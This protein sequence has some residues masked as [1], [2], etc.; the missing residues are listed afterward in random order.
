MPGMLEVWSA[1]QALAMLEKGILMSVQQLPQFIALPDIEFSLLFL[2]VGIERGKKC[3]IGSAYFMH[4]PIDCMH[5]DFPVLRDLCD[6]QG[7]RVEIRQLFIVLQ[8]FL[9]VRDFP[10]ASTL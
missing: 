1:I 10:V 2:A 6:F 3:P 7:I 4:E 9:E 8:H 5:D